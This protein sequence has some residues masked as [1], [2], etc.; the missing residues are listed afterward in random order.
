MLS[1]ISCSRY[2]EYLPPKAEKEARSLIANLAENKRL[3]NNI[4]LSLQFVSTILT[5]SDKIVPLVYDLF[6][7]IRDAQLGGIKYEDLE[8]GKRISNEAEIAKRAYTNIFEAIMIMIRT[9][10]FAIS[11]PLEIERNLRAQ[12]PKSNLIADLLNI[13]FDGDFSSFE[14]KCDVLFSKEFMEYSA[15]DIASLWCVLVNML[16]ECQ[17]IFDNP[18]FKFLIPSIKAN[19]ITGNTRMSLDT[20][21]KIKNIDNEIVRKHIKNNARAFDKMTLFEIFCIRVKSYAQNN[22]IRGIIREP[23]TYFASGMDYKDFPGEYLYYFVNKISEPYALII[24][25]KYSDDGDNMRIASNLLVRSVT[26]KVGDNFQSDVVINALFESVDHAHD[27]SGEIML[28]LLKKNFNIFL[29]VVTDDVNSLNGTYANEINN[30]INKFTRN[31]G[32]MKYAFL[33]NERDLNA[34]VDVLKN[35]LSADR[36]AKIDEILSDRQISKRKMLAAYSLRTIIYAFSRMYSIFKFSMNIVPTGIVNIL[37]RDDNSTNIMSEFLEMIAASLLGPE[38]MIKDEKLSKV[39]LMRDY[40]KY[41]STAE[42]PYLNK[43]IEENALT[44]PDKYKPED[45]IGVF[46][47]AEDINKIMMMTKEQEMMN[48]QREKV[49]ELKRQMLKDGALIKGG[50]LNLEQIRAD[51]LALFKQIDAKRNELSEIK[52]TF[53]SSNISREIRRKM[54]AEMSGMFAYRVTDVRLKDRSVVHKLL[55]NLNQHVEDI[56]RCSASIFNFVLAV[57]YIVDKMS[58]IVNEKYKEYTKLSRM[59]IPSFRYDEIESFCKYNSILG[60]SELKKFGMLQIDADIIKLFIS[61]KK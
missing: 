58:V 9:T 15:Y 29:G 52:Y 41:M 59:M 17:F 46:K 5:I 10:N 40:V 1:K 13:K 30:T 35:K 26:T 57:S 37:W 22:T 28:S 7:I 32:D 4:S 25:K 56:G 27:A 36:E 61:D 39:D 44:V 42:D 24:N 54:I 47:A 6:K 14:K 3:I 48:F 38:F 11:A 43:L 18:L 19:E 60:R 8:S 34:Y 21:E 2:Q 53:E 33:T 51:R 49:E 55:C 23:N 20:Y 50:E 16:S 45:N 12:N 31:G